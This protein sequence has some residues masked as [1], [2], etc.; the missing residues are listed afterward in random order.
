MFGQRY[1]QGIE[2]IGYHN[3]QASDKYLKLLPYHESG[4][5]KNSML[6]DSNHNWNGLYLS[7]GDIN[8][9]LV[10][11]IN[12]L[13]TTDPQVAGQLWNDNGTLKVSSGI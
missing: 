1:K 3:N 13:P 4:V 6:G 11:M 9:N 8:T 5:L 7:K 10:V 2:I 12:D